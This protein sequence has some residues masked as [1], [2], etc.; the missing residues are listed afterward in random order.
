M[1]YTCGD[2]KFFVRWT[3]ERSFTSGTLCGWKPPRVAGIEPW[4]ARPPACTEG[5]EACS[6]FA[7]AVQPVAQTDG[8]NVRL[9]DGRG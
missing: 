1:K 4:G 7:P 8:R 6:M 9:E 3:N 5:M 2:C